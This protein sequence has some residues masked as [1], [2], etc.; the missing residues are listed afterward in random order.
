[1]SLITIHLRWGE[2]SFTIL[3]F[4]S[5]R[6]RKTHIYICEVLFV[7]KYHD[8]KLKLLIM[9]VYSTYKVCK[10][11]RNGCVIPLHK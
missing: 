10:S 4:I 7:K 2:Y 3:I 11:T 8:T 6:T 1:M 9:R 5:Y